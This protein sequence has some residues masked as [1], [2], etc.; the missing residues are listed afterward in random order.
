MYCAVFTMGAPMV[1]GANMLWLEISTIFVAFRWLMFFYGVGGA[2][3]RQ[4]V[5]S[6]FLAFSFILLR[7]VLLIYVAV[8]VGL[9]WLSQT[10]RHETR[11][12][13]YL[14][15]IGEFAVAVAFNIVLNVYW[16]SLIVKQIIRIFT[17][18]ATQAEQS[19]NGEAKQP[20]HVELSE[21]NETAQNAV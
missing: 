13:W 11:P 5:N 4:A 1:F 14:L 10:Y 2:D 21:V 17:R 18:G 7:T 12:I 20:K 6:F 9:P 16:S 19:F 3:I 8:A 15:L